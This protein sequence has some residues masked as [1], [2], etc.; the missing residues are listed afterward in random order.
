M[1]FE[2]SFFERSCNGDL[3]AEVLESLGR[4]QKELPCKLFYDSRG[5]MLF[6]E[7]CN[8]DE[9]YITRTEINI[10]SDNI[11]EISRIIGRNSLLVE[12]GSGSDR[13]IRT[14]LDNNSEPAAY[15]PV[16]I[17]TKYLRESTKELSDDYPGLRIIPVNA[18][19][20]Q[21]FELPVTDMNYD[22]ITVYYPGSTIGNFRPEEA[23]SFLKNIAGL[24]GSKS[25]LLIGFDMKKDRATLEKAYNDSKGITAMFNL[26][27]L[28]NINN[29][30]NADFDLEQWSH[31]AYYNEQEGRIEMHLI[32]L[33]DQKVN[34]NGHEISFS[35]DES[36][37][38]E[39]SYKYSLDE[40]LTLAADVY[41]PEKYWCDA[42]NKFCILNMTAK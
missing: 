37:H 5:S 4:T 23:R 42:N 2:N 17:S 9:Y 29:I 26:N 31:L 7:I 25:S 35:K 32:S 15:V 36:I 13:K 19:Y 8:L 3:L 10:L 34:I 11:N 20:T 6:D 27:I 33:S 22:K 28:R 18:D 12:L 40:F 38:T 1:M 21:R 16:D 39:N 41:E 24:C 14:I 30:L